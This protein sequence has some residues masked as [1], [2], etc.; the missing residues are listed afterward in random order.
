MN[1]C[2]QRFH[3]RKSSFLSRVF[4]RL[5]GVIEEIEIL[6]NHSENQFKHTLRKY[7]YEFEIREYPDYKMP[8]GTDI[9]SK[10]INFTLIFDILQNH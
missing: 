5:N 10:C 3:L 2:V 1:R 7:Q 6:S 9:L 8:A 4:L